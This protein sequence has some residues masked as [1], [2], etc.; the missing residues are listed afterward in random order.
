VE[1]KVTYLLERRCCLQRP[2]LVPD[3]QYLTA[4]WR[5]RL[6]A[7]ATLKLF[8]SGISTLSTI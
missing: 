3:Y 1:E 6:T 4:G 2:L 7:R 5:G 8:H